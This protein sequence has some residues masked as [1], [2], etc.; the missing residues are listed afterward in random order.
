MKIRMDM[1]SSWAALR[2]LVNPVIG[3]VALAVC[4]F[5]SAMANA[6]VTLQN[7]EFASLSGDR[8]EMRLDFDGT[9]PAP[10]SYTIADP[11]RITLDLFDGQRAGFQIP[12]SW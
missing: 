7:I 9:P 5:G 1:V 6:G 10:R 2:A 11:A 8:V 3:A 12:Q 4:L